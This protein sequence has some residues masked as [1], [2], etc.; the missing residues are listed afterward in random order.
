MA[1]RALVLSG[2]GP[3]GV[4]WHSGILTAFEDAGDLPVRHLPS[5]QKERRA[6]PQRG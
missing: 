6:N 4:A 5:N 1:T 3:I 2:G